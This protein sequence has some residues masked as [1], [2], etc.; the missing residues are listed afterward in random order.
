MER[1]KGRISRG[2]GVVMLCAGIA[3]VGFMVFRGLRTPESSAVYAEPVTTPQY[4]IETATRP[5]VDIANWAPAARPENQSAGLLDALDKDAALALAAQGFRSVVLPDPFA[6][7]QADKAG[8]VLD[9]LKEKGVFRILTVTSVAEDDLDAFGQAL[10]QLIGSS[11]FDA[12][13]LAD[14]AG[15]DA[16]GALTTSFTKTI[17]RVLEEAKLSLPVIFDVGALTKNPTAYQDAIALL[18]GS[19]ENAELLVHGSA[20]QANQLPKLAEQLAGALPFSALFDLKTAIPNGTLA[21]TVQFLSALQDVQGVP[22]MLD[23]ACNLPKNKE[24]AALLQKFFAGA[25][26]LINAAKGLELSKPL[27]GLKTSQDIYTDA[28]VITF[29]GTSSPLFTLTCNGKDVARNESGDFS[30]DMPLQPGKNVFEFVYQNKTYIVNVYYSVTV[31]ESVSPR[32][33]LETTGGIELVVSASARRGST[34]KAALGPQT[35]TLQP[36]SAGEEEDGIN[37]SSE[38][39]SEFINYTGTFKLPA[40]RASNYVVGTLVFTASFQGLTEKKNGALVTVLP[41]VVVLPPA[42]ETTTSSTSSSSS[43]T[44]T[45]SSSSTPSSSSSSSSTAPGNK[46][47]AESSTTSGAST[48]TGNRPSTES[49]T[50]T[51]ASTTTETDTSTSSESSTSSKPGKQYT[52]YSNNG[53]GTAQ[54]VEITGSWANARWNGT[55]DTSYNP[56]ASPL[57]AGCFDYVTGKQVI[58]GTTYYQLGSGKRI[59][60]VDLKVIDKGYKLPSNTLRASSSV[61]GALTMRFGIDWKIPFHVDFISQSYTASEGFNGNVY[62]VKSFTATALEIT[63]CHTSSY[64]GSI[65]IGSFPLISNAQWS[66]DTAKNTVTL[67]LTFKEAGKFYGWQAYY[68]GGDLVIKLSPKPPSSLKGAVIWLDPGHGGKDP[69]A[70]YAASHATL[71]DEKLVT[72]IIATK[73]KNKLEAAGATVY[74][75]RSSD[76]YVAPGDRVRMT[77]QRNPDMFISIHTDSTSTAAP[78]GTSAFYYRAFSQ[79]LAKAVHNRIVATYKNNI[80]IAG[81]GISNY[82]DML[83]RVDRGTKFYPFEVTRIEEC[84]ALLIEYGFGSNLTECKVLQTEKYQDLFAQATADGIADWLKAQ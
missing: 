26:D 72:I 64:T 38:K 66:K 8:E 10:G 59:K 54:M 13:L 29:A 25:L 61:S 58:D 60:A 51:G 34:V 11:S 24:A 12:L 5:H 9:A 73:L 47:S 82:K 63:F 52:P 50:T 68:D 81:N 45:S 79:P 70:P 78:S 76:T 18:A 27:K 39:D 35:I 48:P 30:A 20:S 55:S 65:N 56:T 2:I 57:L 37:A 31:L 69:G 67:K 75:S 83:S 71:K 44:S 41:E 23:S 84:P 19:L 14:N 74:M 36:G 53:L 33:G 62:G 7:G 17:S 40:S 15:T 49:S 42:P 6:A 16:N 22:L 3:A 43:S 28:P 1:K 80:Y 21:E 46:P 32:G 77:R 4:I